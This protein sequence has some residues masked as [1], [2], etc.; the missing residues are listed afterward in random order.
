MGRSLCL[1]V[2][3]SWVWHRYSVGHHE[4]REP[5]GF[6]RK[7]SNSHNWRTLAAFSVAIVVCSVESISLAKAENTLWRKSPVCWIAGEHDFSAPLRAS[8]WRSREYIAVL[9]PGP[10]KQT[11]TLKHVAHNDCINIAM[12]TRYRESRPNNTPKVLVLCPLV[13]R[14]IKILRDAVGGKEFPASQMPDASRWSLAR[15]LPMRYKSPRMYRS[16]ARVSHFVDPKFDRRNIS[17]VFYDEGIPGKGDT[18]SS[19]FGGDFGGADSSACNPPK[20]AG[21]ESHYNTGERYNETLIG[22][23]RVDSTGEIQAHSEAR[24]DDGEF[25]FAKGLISLIVLALL[26]ANLKRF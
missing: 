23:R 19:R 1:R 7:I 17:S 3:P 4:A 5:S 11:V 2:R 13:V 18:I 10:H 22:V 25:F 15:I 9:N 14:E 6:W 20:S 26:Y 8:Y 21:E 24:L 12:R 16:R